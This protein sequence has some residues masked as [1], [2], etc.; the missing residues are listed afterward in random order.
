MNVLVLNDRHAFLTVPGE[1][2]CILDADIRRFAGWLGYAHCTV[3]GLTNDAVGYIISRE[4]WRHRTYEST[5]SFLGPDL[6]PFVLEQAYELLHQL[7]PTGAYHG[8]RTH[9]QQPV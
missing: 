2:S 5:V 3:L 4:S 7:E 9:V 6:G 1:L 8:S